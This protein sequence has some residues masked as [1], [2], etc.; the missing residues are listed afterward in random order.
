MFSTFSNIVK[1]I[2]TFSGSIVPSGI[3]PTLA[4]VIAVPT[5]VFGGGSRIGNNVDWLYIM[6]TMLTSSSLVAFLMPLG[7]CTLVLS[8]SCKSVALLLTS[9][10]ESIYSF[11]S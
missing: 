3:P 5:V 9:I 11:S 8:S 7:K 4:P 10:T 1:F 6:N 2:V